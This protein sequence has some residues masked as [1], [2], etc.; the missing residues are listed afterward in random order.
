[1]I[2]K[3]GRLIK[4]RGIILMILL[5]PTLS[6]ADHYYGGYIVYTHV[7]GFEYHVQVITYA[8]NDKVNSDRDSIQIRWGDMEE[9]WMPRTNNVGN[10][11]TIYPGVKKN[12]YELSHTFPGPGN[13]QLVFLDQFRMFD[14]NNMTAGKSGTTML[15]FDAIIPVEDTLSYCI[16]T[17]AKPLFEPF[18]WVKSGEEFRMN[19][20]HFDQ[21]GDSLS[22][23]LVTPKA[24]NG[25]P[26]PGYWRPNDVSINAET[27][28]FVWENPLWGTYLFAYQV[29][30]FRD[31]VQ[32]GHLIVDFPVFVDPNAIE[33]GT[34][35]AI[36]NTTDN[37]VYF[38]GPTTEDFMI[39]Y[40]NP[41]A[42]S[43]FLE[44]NG[45]YNSSI[46]F[47]G[48]ESKSSTGQEAFD[49]LS[50]DYFGNDKQQG[51]HIVTYKAVSIFGSDTIYDYT[52]FLIRTESDTSWGCT[53]P[54]DIKVV[55][56]IAPDLPN[57]S[58]APNLFDESVWINLG[59]SFSDIT[60]EIYDSRGRLVKTESNFQDQTVKLELGELGR[61]MYLFRVRT[62]D[63]VLTVMKAVRR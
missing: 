35:S 46:Y 59:T 56:E 23:K 5:L 38:S 16:N 26:V 9:E 24:K 53:V 27:G 52:S 63:R 36:E 31:G 33:R 15:Y 18:M 3:I 20:C 34:F 10:G 29:S 28:Q 48:V 41:L 12:I 21:E 43:V 11:E 6:Y 62:S 61:A 4:M 14:V 58:I 32:I 8:D 49:T 25:N 60:I 42:D 1:M 45:G 57:L 50:L 22:F 39:S 13:Y 37:E 17:S 44:V 7:S 40:E 54:P 30:E 55:E 47:N 51:G 19:L 2:E